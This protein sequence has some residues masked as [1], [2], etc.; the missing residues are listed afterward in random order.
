MK[1]VLLF[2]IGLMGSTLPVI[3]Q[4]IGIGT[5]NPQAM[6]HVQNGSVLFIAP[7]VDDVTPPPISGQGNRMM[8][9]ANKAAFRAGRAFSSEWDKANVGAYSFAS[10]FANI[11]SGES[12]QALGFSNKALGEAASTLGKH[13]QASGIGAVALGAWDSAFGSFSVAIGNTNASNANSAVA[14]GSNNI[15]NAT[16]SMAIGSRTIANA[17]ESISLGAYNDPV[18]GV[19]ANSRVST[20]PL[21]ILGNGTSDASRSNALV[22]TKNG[23]FGMGTNTPAALMHLS[24]GSSTGNAQLLLEE[25]GDASDGA[26]ISFRNASRTDKYWDLWGY[27]DA[28]LSNAAFNFYYSAAASNIFSLQ[29]NGN[30][31]LKGTLTQNSDARLKKDIEPLDN[32]LDLLQQ[33]NGYHYHWKDAQRDQEM[34]TGLLAQEV[35]KLMPELVKEDAD[36]VK[37]VNYS[38]MIPYLLEAIKQQQ[39][40]IDELKA[41][42]ASRHQL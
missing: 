22:V 3:G 13:N 23:R 32:S 14:L 38:G 9:Y 33:L 25:K 19:N 8:W 4:N 11:A 42:M 27:T 34:Q 28:T 40:Q 35:E 16:L 10:G 6:L 26:R 24:S 15:A 39:K 41:A 30:A 7:N 5:A 37:S 29:G 18:A 17:Y 21:F 2:A 31:W 12:S 1:S 20:D 36:G